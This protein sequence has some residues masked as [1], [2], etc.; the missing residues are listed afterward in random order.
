[1]WVGRNNASIYKKVENLEKYAKENL[2]GRITGR[3]QDKSKHSPQ[4]EFETKL[5]HITKKLNTK[6]A[7]LIAKE[8]LDFYK[9]FLD[10]LEKEIQGE[11]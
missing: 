1:V 8:R 2:S 5:K 3:I 10:R 11:L 7:K 4:I 6:K 9:K